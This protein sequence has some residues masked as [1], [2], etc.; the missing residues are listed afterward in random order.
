MKDVQNRDS[1]ASKNK[2]QGLRASANMLLDTVLTSQP[3]DTLGKLG[4]KPTAWDA[5]DQGDS[6]AEKSYQ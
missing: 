2:H 3:Y 5:M 1:A 6:T 4:R